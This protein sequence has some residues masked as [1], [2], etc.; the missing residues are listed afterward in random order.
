M[1]QPLVAP[2]GTWKSPVSL[3]MVGHGTAS[4]LRI[5]LDGPDTYW[6]EVRPAEDGRTVIVKRTPDGKLVDITPPGLSSVSLVNEYGARS[7]TVANGVVYFSNNSDQRVYR[8]RPGEAPVPITTE[9]GFRYGTRV[10]DQGRGR[11]VCI[12]ENHTDPDED[13]PLSEIV[14]LDF[15]GNRETPSPAGRQ[16][17]P[18]FAPSQSRW[19]TAG[20][21]HL[22][23]PQYAMGRHGAMGGPV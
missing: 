20:V 5:A 6:A 21:A 8:Q 18:Q 16:R 17:F 7:Y 4:L 13:H 22:G 3:E 14:A 2:Y 1:S 15:E 12:R 19:K 23:P 9:T 10:V 11:I